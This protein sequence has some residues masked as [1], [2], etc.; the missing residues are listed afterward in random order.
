M[1][2]SASVVYMHGYT[3]SLNVLLTTHAEALCIVRVNK[4]SQ[5]GKQNEDRI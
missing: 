5:Q 2:V 3:V 1:H 4:F